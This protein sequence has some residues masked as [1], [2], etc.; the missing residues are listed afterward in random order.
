MKDRL[1]DEIDQLGG[2]PSERPSQVEIR[3]NPPEGPP[4]GFWGKLLAAL[5]A[6]G[7]IAELL[8]EVFK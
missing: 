4:K 1:R 2:F 7:A 5:L 8:H 6:L 3:W